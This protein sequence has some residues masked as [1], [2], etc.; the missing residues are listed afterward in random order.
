MKSNKLHFLIIA[1]VAAVW[2]GI[3]IWGSAKTSSKLAQQKAA[4]PRP[5]EKPMSA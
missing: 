5:Q 2:L 4:A 3:F 1:L